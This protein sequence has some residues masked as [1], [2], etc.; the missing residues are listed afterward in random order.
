MAPNKISKNSRGV[1]GGGGGGDFLH[2]GRPI[3]NLPKPMW[4]FLNSQYYDL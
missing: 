4:I 1:R 2:M 3:G